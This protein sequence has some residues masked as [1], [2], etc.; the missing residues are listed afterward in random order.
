MVVCHLVTFSDRKRMAARKRA[1]G[2]HTDA[3]NG[4]E[5][6]GNNYNNGVATYLGDIPLAVRPPAAR[7]RTRRGAARGSVFYVF[8][9]YCLL[10]VYNFRPSKTTTYCGFQPTEIA[11]KPKGGHAASQ[12]RSL[13]T[14]TPPPCQ[15]RPYF[16]LRACLFALTGSLPLKGMWEGS[17][18]CRFHPMGRCSLRGQ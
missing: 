4:S 11:C 8:A 3:L 9:T 15:G 2:L 10:N 18:R 17:V 13:N 1:R 5:A 7:H 14:F 12:S 16:L 6:V